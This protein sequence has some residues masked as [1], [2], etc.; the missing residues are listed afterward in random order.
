[1]SVLP[2]LG[3]TSC[4]DSEPTAPAG[5]PIAFFDPGQRSPVTTQTISEFK[6]WARLDNWKPVMNGVTVTR[7]GLNKWSYSPTVDWPDEPVNFYAVSPATMNMSDVYYGFDLYYECKGDIDLLV[8]VRRNVHQSDGRIKLN[9][10]HTLARITTDITT[11]LT[12]TI[13]E[14]RRISI[15]DVG[16]AG[17]LHVP[18]KDTSPDAPAGDITDC[19][20]I[21]NMSATNFDVYNG[22]PVTLSGT[23]FMPLDGA[24]FML[25]VRLTP[26]LFTGYIHGSAIRVV[27]RMIDRRTGEVIWPTRQ[28]PAHL[29]PHDTPGWGVA[30]LALR[31]AT[32]DA[33]WLSG[34]HYHYTIQIKGE[35]A[36]PPTSATSATSATAPGAP[37][38]AG[39]THRHLQSSPQIQLNCTVDSY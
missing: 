27:Y 14:V 23:R 19:W 28:T 38:V 32:P 35:P 5:S 29:R 25:P 24:E 4:S 26:L 36:T 12:D 22:E 31:S 18:E 6:V 39:D 8:A 7:T 17:T 21:W 13:V 1:M 33:R 20:Q 9:F 30:N 34:H 37:C 11:P 3:G 10:C 2:L 16:S 15:A